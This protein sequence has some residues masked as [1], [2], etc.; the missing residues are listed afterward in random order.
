MDW[1]DRIGR[2]IRLRDLHVVMAVADCGSMTK[3]AAQLA[4]SHPVVSKTISDLEQTLGIKLFDRMTQGVALTPYGQALLKCGTT[5]FDE[6]R[7]GLRQIEFLANPDAGELRIG[8]PEITMAG[9][10]PAIVERFSRQYPRVSLH[11]ELVNIAMMQFQELR[12]RRIDLLIGRTPRPFLE[13][14]LSAETLFDEP[15]VAVA[16]L[17]SCWAGRRKLKLDDLMN[18]Q[19]VLPPYDSVPGTLIMEIFREKNLKPPQPAVVSL[20]V[21]LTVSLIAGGGF[22]GV[23]PNS[24]AQLNRRKTGLKILPLK[25]GTSRFAFG[26]ITARNRTV[27]PLAELF[28]ACTRE[29][30]S[31]IPRLE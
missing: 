28:I 27:S 1:A 17:Q 6:M 3:A 7:L 2:R 16:G 25:L 11:V 15:F 31:S 5:V 21:Q 24:V 13:D 9:L 30:A 10:L 23:L 8:S 18:E 12:D 20:S 19:W 14:D 4:I 29:I 22:V 26:I